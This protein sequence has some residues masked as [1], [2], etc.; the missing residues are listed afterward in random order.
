ML[1]LQRHDIHLHLTSMSINKN[2]HTIA[3]L[4]SA[5]PRRGMQ[6]NAKQT[7]NV[8]T[9]DALLRLQ[10]NGDMLHHL[11]VVVVVPT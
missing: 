11:H 1:C 10:C 4:P 9:T 5:I 8:P 2:V 7:S 6:C 3:C